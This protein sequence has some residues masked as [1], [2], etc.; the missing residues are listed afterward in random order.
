LQNETKASWE[1]LGI[2]KQFIHAV[3]ELGFQFPTE[4]QAKCAPPIINGQNVIGIAQ[5]GTGKTAAYLL[6]IL[7]R[8]KHHVDTGPRTLVLLPTKELVI[9]IYNQALLFAKYTDLRISALYGGV[10][11]KTQLEILDN[12]VDAIVA[13]PGRFEELYLKGA[14]KPKSIKFLVVDEADRMMDM[15]FMPQLRKI[16]EWLP[17]KRQNLLFS[18]TF[19]E[20]V[21]RLAKEYIDFAA[22]IETTPQATTATQV[23]QT[24][25]KVPNLKTKLNLL[26]WLL[27]NKTFSRVIIFVRTKS[28]VT[29]LG[30][31]LERMEIG[32]IRTIHSNKGQNSRINAIQDFSAGDVRVLISTD[33]AA[34]G[35]DIKSVSHVI[36]FDVPMLYEDYVHRVGRTGRAF[37]TGEALTFVTP[38]DEYHIK[39]IETLIREKITLR[40]LPKELTIEDTPFEE[41]QTIAREI[42]RQRR[43]EDSTYQGAFHDRKR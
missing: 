5:T 34:R 13:T 2:T 25:Y 4:I 17:P 18:A 19:P 31:F 33:V 30:K 37:E 16:L 42:D 29:S 3:T 8:L 38:A 10:G 23:T 9:Q 40:A 15:H 11:P 28:T 39:K 35:I 32:N 14:I 12:G 20:R 43:K 22:R 6:P 1:E 41:N 7:Y 26:K 27:D 36:N 21:E 24:L